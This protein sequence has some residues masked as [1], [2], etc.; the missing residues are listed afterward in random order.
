MTGRVAADATAILEDPAE[1]SAVHA[2]GFYGT[3]DGGSVALD[4]FETVYLAE[5][6]RV[7]LAD[8]GGRPVP[9]PDLFRRASRADG[10]FGIRYVVYR[11]LRQRGYVVRAS[12]PPVSFSV[13][14][15]G[16]VLHKTPAKFWVDAQSERA[17][18]SLDRALDLADRASGARKLLLLAVVDEE[19]DLTYYR[20]RRASPTGALEAPILAHPARA[21]LSGDR[22]VIFDPEAVRLLGTEGSYG[23]RIGERLELGVIEAEH[24]RASGQIE[25]RDARS[26]RQVPEA[27]FLK[28]ARALE[29]GFDERLRAYRELRTRR[30]LVKTGFKYGAHFRAYLRSPDRVHARYLV[31]AVAPAA[32]IPWPEVAGGVRLAQGVRKEFLFA[33]APSVGPVRFLG[34]ERVR[35]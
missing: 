23:S 34:L 27:R 8:G 11:D 26:A 5:T 1:A 4:R 10:E 7:Q 2:R 22:L 13:L 3:V 17:P 12:P 19:S 14:P 20:V 6:A 29:P 33:W 25:I 9:W 30:L 15:R 16:G 28:R 31:R 18:F 24:L 35:P 21:W 32:R